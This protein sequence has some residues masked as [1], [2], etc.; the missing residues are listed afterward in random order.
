MTYKFHIIV[1]RPGYGGKHMEGTYSHKGDSLPVREVQSRF[2]A[3]V[4][5]DLELRN[6]ALRN[7]DIRVV[8]FRRVPD[9]QEE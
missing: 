7:A 1:S 5:R 6:L 3:D 9:E 4:R 8:S 2:V